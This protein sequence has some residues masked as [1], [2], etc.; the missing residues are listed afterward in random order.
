MVPVFKEVRI[1]LCESEYSKYARVFAT[2]ESAY[3]DKVLIK[4]SQISNYE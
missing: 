2:F 3:L 1:V 4:K